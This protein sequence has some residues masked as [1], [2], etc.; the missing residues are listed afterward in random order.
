[1]SFIR[2]YESSEKNASTFK[3]PVLILDIDGT[4]YEDDCN[5]E[6]QIK[7]N[8]HHFA[9]NRFGIDPDECERLHRDYGCGIRGI[10]EEITGNRNIFV[11]YFNEVFSNLDLSKLNKYTNSATGT[12]I[13]KMQRV[14]K[15]LLSLPYPIILASNSPVFHVRK[16]LSRLGLGALKPAM[17]LTPE[18][19]GGLTKNEEDFWAPLLHTYPLSLYTPTLLD[20]NMR[21]IECVRALGIH[22]VHVTPKRHL[23]VALAEFICDPHHTLTH[24]HNTHA[25]SLNHTHT[26]TSI[27]IPDDNVY[28]Q[29]KNVVDKASINPDTLQQVVYE[30]RAQGRGEVRVL[31]VGAGHVNMLPILMDALT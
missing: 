14:H 3:T 13:G 18:R 1:M 29:S 24:T 26:H 7:D 28:I 22:A 19:R 2:S 21:K 23:E 25:H 11:D 4:I 8:F 12:T 20:D 15:A 30:L 6:Q 16:V 9:L 5:I 31:D 10:A 27:Y 17:V